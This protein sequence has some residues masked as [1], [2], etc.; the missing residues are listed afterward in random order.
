MGKSVGVVGQMFLKPCILPILSKRINVLA[1][2]ENF[3]AVDL[4]KV[5]AAAACKNGSCAID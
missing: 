2:W 1:E 4:E 3:D 5:E